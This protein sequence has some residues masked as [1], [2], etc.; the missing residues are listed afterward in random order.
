MT[1]FCLVNESVPTDFKCFPSIVEPADDE[2]SLGHSIVIIGGKS[3]RVG[4]AALA[5]RGGDKRSPTDD[6]HIG[7]SEHLGCLHS[8]I[9]TSEVD[10][11]ETLCLGIPDGLVKINQKQLIEKLSGSIDLGFGRHCEIARVHVIGQGAAASFGVKRIPSRSKFLTIDC[12]HKTTIVTLR[13]DREHVT[14]RSRTLDFGGSM[15]LVKISKLFA[16]S[17]SAQDRLLSEIFTGLTLGRKIVYQG[18]NIEIN[19]HLVQRTTWAAEL[20]KRIVEVVRTFDDI[21]SIFLSGGAGEFL[22][23]ALR[24]AAPYS[25]VQIQD[26]PRFAVLRGLI[27]IARLGGK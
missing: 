1:K 9:L 5:L 3:F 26:D 10:S 20:T 7:S 11:L 27:R 21:P 15:L 8:A 13:D 23:P 12:G 4:R 18:T 14:Q 2:T 19:Q 17:D 16:Q 6:G 24:I 25:R 22:E